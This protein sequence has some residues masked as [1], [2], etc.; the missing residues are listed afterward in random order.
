MKP[1]GFYAFCC[2]IFKKS[3][4]SPGHWSN[5]GI[6]FIVDHAGAGSTPA[7]AVM[8]LMVAEVGNGDHWFE[9]TGANRMP[10]VLDNQWH[11]QAWAYD[12]ATSN[13]TITG[14]VSFGLLN[15]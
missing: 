4:S 15:P 6:L 10:N 7:A 14:M 5:A 9:L 13:M 3:K 2:E 11:H 12:E 1:N 8:K